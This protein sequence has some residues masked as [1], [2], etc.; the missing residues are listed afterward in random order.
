MLKKNKSIILFI[1]LA[2]GLPTIKIK[3][4]TSSN[5][6]YTRYGYGTLSDRSFGAGR[7]MGGIGFGLRSKYQINPMNPASYSA[8][9]SLTFLFDFG[10]A[11]SVSSFKDDTN[12]ENNF[13]GNFEYMALQFPVTS[14]LALS[15]GIL[16]F[17]TVGYTFGASNEKDDVS[18]TETYSGEGNLSEIYIGGA[19]DIIKDR[20]S[21]GVNVSYL[22]G[23]LT[24]TSTST[25]SQSGAYSMNR[26]QKIDV[27]DVRFDIGAQYTYPIGKE[28]WLTFGLSISPGKK[29]HSKS[30]DYAILTDGSVYQ[31][32][33]LKNAD[34]GVATKI[35]FGVTYNKLD[36]V[37][38]GADILYED[39]GNQ[40]YFGDTDYFKN[41]TRIALG[42]EYIINTKARN[43]FSRTRY[44]AGV[45]YSNSYVNIKGNGVDEYGA[46]FGLGLPLVD[47]RS[48]LNI[49]FEY[50]NIK[51]NGPT[52]IKENYFRF[53]LNYT[54][55]ELWFF[56]R[57]IN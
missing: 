24:H 38:L 44:R 20:L 32:D 36:H 26:Y 40:K 27:N 17:S 41:R 12:T 19:Y 51:P 53:T 10:V 4:Q 30:Y 23:N 7:S 29:L 6:P 55:N 16:P 2:L 14:Q 18:Y 45:H 54:F 1:C 33:T 21:L 56:K 13:N 3:A 49:G 43:I 39:W 31:S 28:E 25:I 5:S 22:F 8:M 52:M 57:K 34:N 37:T 9:D 48:L 50:I 15:A 11:G 47:N 46:S 35:G 42:G